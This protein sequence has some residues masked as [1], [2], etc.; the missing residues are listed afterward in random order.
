MP[1]KRRRGG[2]SLEDILVKQMTNI[3]IRYQES[4]KKSKNSDIKNELYNTNAILQYARQSQPQFRRKSQ[5]QLSKA[6]D[7]AISELKKSSEVIEID[8]DSEFEVDDNVQLMEVK[9]TNFFNRSIQNMYKNT[10]N[11]NVVNDDNQSVS[12]SVIEV[13][14]NDKKEKGSIFPEDTNRVPRQTSAPPDLKSTVN[15]DNESVTT[16]NPSK[17]LRKKSRTVIDNVESKKRKIADNSGSSNENKYAPPAVKLENVGGIEHIL[18]DIIQL[19]LM[20]FK[21]LEIHLHLGIKPPRGILLHGPPGCGKTLLANAIAGELNVPFL[22]ISAPS[23]VSGMS[24][25][26]EKKLREIFEEAKEQAPCLL[27]IDE[28][29]AI[30]PKRETAQ[31]E[32][33]R[34]IVAQLLTCLDDLSLEKNQQ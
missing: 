5:A 23:I 26:S 19:I 25:E 2:G 30:T 14:N 4:L 29:D 31:R 10:N 17:R 34:R 21:H 13:K 20:P 28:I 7:K 27:F 11:T 32:M 9:D 6:V 12:S 15:S 8:S 16:P 1:S 18:Q 24:G 3:I 33:E 22:S